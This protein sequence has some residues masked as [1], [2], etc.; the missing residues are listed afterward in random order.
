M[1]TVGVGDGFLYLVILITFY[2]FYII[3]LHLYC[4]NGLSTLIAFQYHFLIKIFH[5]ENTVSYLWLSLYPLF[6]EKKF[7][8][9]DLVFSSEI[10]M[11]AVLLIQSF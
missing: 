4:L 3:L 9:N 1:C 6:K 10:E 11:H 7:D 2:K 8:K 5:M